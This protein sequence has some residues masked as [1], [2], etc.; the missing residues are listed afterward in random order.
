MTLT[1]DNANKDTL[2]LIE[3][4]LLVLLINAFVM[5]ITIKVMS[6]SVLDVKL[7]TF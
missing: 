3:N 1:V 6:N 7:V 5:Q 4:V 2:M